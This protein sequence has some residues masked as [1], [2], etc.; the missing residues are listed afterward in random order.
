MEFE[1]IKDSA[2][3]ELTCRICCNQIKSIAISI[4]EEFNATYNYA[5]IIMLCF[6]VS[7]MKEDNLPHSICVMCKKRIQDAYNLRELCIESD[8][9]LRDIIDNKVPLFVEV[10]TELDDDEIEE[11]VNEKEEQTMGS[12]LN[13][14]VKDI[15][16]DHDKNYDILEDVKS[17]NSD[18]SEDSNYVANTI[19]VPKKR[20]H[21]TKPKNF[22]CDVCNSRHGTQRSLD[23]HKIIH[24]DLVLEHT[25]IIEVPK[26]DEYKCCYCTMTF[27]DILEMYEHRK[28]E[29]IEDQQDDNFKCDHC[30]KK[31]KT[32]EALRYHI[33]KHT[34]NKI[35]W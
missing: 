26:L 7:I 32:I 34:N 17:D 9:K 24:S 3:Y 29:H 5:F 1:D 4:F 35:S 23:H 8:R 11:Y 13:N 2:G 31:V 30:S 15:C 20:N 18:D 33:R 10:K 21:G 28:K 19:K 25:S 6:P 22:I 27:K 12:Y 14:D 16:S